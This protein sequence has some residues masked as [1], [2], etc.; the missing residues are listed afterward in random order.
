MSE[1]FPVAPVKE[2]RREQSGVA[3]DVARAIHDYATPDEPPP[4]EDVKPLSPGVL[5]WMRA[6]HRRI[7][8]WAYFAVS[9]LFMCV[10]IFSA[11]V[12][13]GVVT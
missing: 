3:A 10:S 6:A 9:V 7:P 1:L 4:F 12:R 11:L 8:D 5:Q 13:C 2:T